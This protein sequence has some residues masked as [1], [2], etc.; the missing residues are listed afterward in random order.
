M[1]A[2]KILFYLLAWALGGCLPLMSLHPLYGEKDL[3]FEEK[4][5]GVWVDDANQPETMWQFTRPDESKAAYQLT[6]KDDEG[7]TGIFEAHLVKLDN[8]LFLDAR[9]D[10]F[11]SGKREAEE[12]ELAYNAFFFVP[13]HTFIKID[14]TAPVASCPEHLGDEAEFDAD[15]LKRLSDDYD[16]V[17]RLR[18]SKT[19]GLENI[20]KEDPNA[21]KHEDVDDHCI[22]LTASTA[23]LQDF[24]TKYAEDEGLFGEETVLIRKKPQK[25]CLSD[26]QAEKG[27]Q[28]TP[29]SEAPAK[30]EAKDNND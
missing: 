4:L 20:L 29:Q 23:E 13:V 9:P 24:I 27:E 12:E 22:I 3:L 5:V 25:Q 16:L 28:T 11:P 17:L 26:K 30:N 15:E 6:F 21:V 14:F 18:L 19:E 10:R 7:K 8:L 2:R 1:E